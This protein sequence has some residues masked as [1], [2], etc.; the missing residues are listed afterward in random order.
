MLLV[1]HRGA[2]AYEPENTLRS[3]RKGI[4]LGANAVEFDVRFTKDKKAVI[5]HDKDVDRTTNGKGLVKEYTLK[6]LKKLN[7]GKKE[8]IPTLKEA[9]TLVKKLKATPIVELKEKSNVKEAVKEIGKSDANAFVLSFHTEAIRQAKQIEP[10]LTAGL[11]F[12]NKI[13]NIQGF[14]RLGKVIKADWLFGEKKAINKQL[15]DTAHKWKFKVAVW[16]C[17]TEADIRKF[18]KLGVDG[19]ASDK[20]DLFKSLK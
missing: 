16:V 4:Q 14:M 2:R 9:L 18:L 15:V 19:I 7:A 11:N 13:R 6:A 17:N 20:P 3:F 8:R 5:V 10:K 1:G 12:S